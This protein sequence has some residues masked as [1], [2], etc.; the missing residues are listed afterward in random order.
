MVRVDER[1]IEIANKFIDLGVLKQKNYD[2]C[3]HI[4]A[5]IV[6]KCDAIVSWNFKHIVNHKTMAGVK[7]VTAQEGYDDLFIYS[8]MAIIGGEPNDS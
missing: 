5:A 1:T 2:D 7:M 4:A 6:S 3:R 8:P